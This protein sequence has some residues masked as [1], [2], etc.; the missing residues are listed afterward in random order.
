MDFRDIAT[1]PWAPNNE[2]QW[3]KWIASTAFS[4][5]IHQVLIDANDVDM[6]MQDPRIAGFQFESVPSQGNEPQS[7]DSRK[8]NSFGD[9]N[10]L[11]RHVLI[12][13]DK[14]LH[15]SDFT[16]VDVSS[17]ALNSVHVPD[18]ALFKNLEIVNAGDNHLVRYHATMQ[19]SIF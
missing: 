17:K 5:P 9:T 10:V 2:K 6:P 7:N 14:E 16:M 19:E 12:Q 15:P 3:R 4:K 8:S 1:E 13:S 18:L 11:D